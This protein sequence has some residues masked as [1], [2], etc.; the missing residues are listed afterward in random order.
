[1]PLSLSSVCLFFES[2]PFTIS[3]Y[4]VKNCS[5]LPFHTKS[6]PPQ[7]AEGEEN[8]FKGCLEVSD[9]RRREIDGSLK[10]EPMLIENPGRFVLFPIQDDE[11]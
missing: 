10:P 7:T 8:E 6:S 11:V 4:L 9:M 5:I 2:A 1:M 3:Y